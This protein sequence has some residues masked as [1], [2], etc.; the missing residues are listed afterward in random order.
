MSF[1]VPTASTLQYGAYRVTQ[2]LPNAVLTRLSTFANFFYTKFPSWHD[3]FAP[4]GFLEPCPMAFSTDP[5]LSHTAD[6]TA[7]MGSNVLS[8]LILNKKV[9]V[10]GYVQAIEVRPAD[11]TYNHDTYYIKILPFDSNCLNRYNANMD[12]SWAGTAG[13]LKIYVP[14]GSPLPQTVGAPIVAW[15]DQVVDLANGWIGLVCAADSWH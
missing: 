9:L 11:A 12:V 13:C 10:H 6:A 4:Q 1:L 8:K 7:W 2:W 15:G 5:T 3:N 14:I